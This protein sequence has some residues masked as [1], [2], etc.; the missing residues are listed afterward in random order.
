M[1]EENKVRLMTRLEIY[2]KHEKNR[3]LVKSRYYKSDYVRLNVLKTWVAATVVY[4]TIVGA[5]VFMEFDKLLAKINE[6]DYF[7]VMYK[8]LGG[9]VM[10][11]LVYFFFSNILYKY[12]YNKAKPG[13]IKYNS[14]L[15]DLIELQGGPMHR[16]KVVVKNDVKAAQDIPISQENPKANTAQRVNR[17][18]ILKQ[19]QEQAEKLREQ[20]IIENVKQ[21]NARIAAQQ[22]AKKKLEQQKAEERARMQK[23][24]LER[25]QMT[26]L[27]GQQSSQI[28]RE[29][30]TY[31]GR[32]N[33]TDAERRNK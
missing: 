16:A 5:Y 31:T 11:C 17:S 20:Q 29:N 24:I 28:R 3:D 1:V 2:E 19:R 8:L 7:D 32:T 12:R 22:E 4:W 33:G 6:V 9:Y 15:K 26:R 13:L 21:R 27:R 18:A 14:T 23:Q 30:Y 10:V 25:E